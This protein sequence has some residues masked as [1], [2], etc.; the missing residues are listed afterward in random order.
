MNHSVSDG[1]SRVA[2]ARIHRTRNRSG[3]TSI[4]GDIPVGWTFVKPCPRSLARRLQCA[5]AAGGAS[6]LSDH[7]PLW[8]RASSNRKGIVS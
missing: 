8:G 3:G 2:A 5:P 1:S 6:S 4:M 7:G